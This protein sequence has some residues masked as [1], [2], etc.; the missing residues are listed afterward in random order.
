MI[1][2]DAPI[3]YYKFENLNKFSDKI[4]HFVTTRK[5]LDKIDFSIGLNGYIPDDMVVSNR[6][7]LASQFN[8]G[9]DC[10]TFSN[11]IHGNKV[12]LLSEIDKGLGA[13]KRETAIADTDAMITDNPRVCIVAQSADCV[14][15]LFYDPLNNVIATAHAGWKGTVLQIT[16]NVINSFINNYNT[17]PAHLIVGIGPCIGSCCY[18]VGNDVIAQVKESFTNTDELIFRIPKFANPVFDLVK[19]NYNTLIKAGIDPK[20]LEIANICTKCNNRHFFS[21]RAGDQGRFGAFLMIL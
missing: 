17:N 4:I 7:T 9:L 6:N 1:F 21:S 13:F 8:L 12:A 5:Y 20:N 16:K 3:P 10:F 19:A 15:I 2:C 18:E 14:P 11:Q